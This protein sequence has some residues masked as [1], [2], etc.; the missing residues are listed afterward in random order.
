M[1]TFTFDVLLFATMRVNAATE[2]EAR[3]KLTDQIDNG[4]ANFGLLDG[5]PVV[6]GVSFNGA[7][8]L[9][10]IDGEPV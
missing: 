2:D 6:C 5:E 3:A 9:I 1:T 8:E 4:E 10:E 7:P